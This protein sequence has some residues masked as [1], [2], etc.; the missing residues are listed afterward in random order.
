MNITSHDNTIKKMIE[1]HLKQC[2]TEF[3]R[4]SRETKE[5]LVDKS[6]S[7]YDQPIF[8][9]FGSSLR[10]YSLKEPVVKFAYKSIFLLSLFMRYHQ[11]SFGVRDTKNTLDKL[12]KADVSFDIITTK[13]QLEKNFFLIF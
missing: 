6:G 5:S 7:G 4:T 12:M 10:S 3:F 11:V 8:Q 9:S 13:S 1:I 2:K